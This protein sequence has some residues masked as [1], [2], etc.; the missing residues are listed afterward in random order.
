[1]NNTYAARSHADDLVQ[2]KLMSSRLIPAC[3][4]KGYP[5]IADYFEMG[6]VN[7]VPSN[8]ETG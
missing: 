4:P 2:P 3:M 5:A 1:M 8:Y 6:A 7:I